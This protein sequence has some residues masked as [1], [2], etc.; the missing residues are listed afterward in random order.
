MSTPVCSHTAPDGHD[1]SGVP[2]QYRH[3]L[4]K[5][6]QCGAHGG[7]GNWKQ[8]AGC[9]GPG[10]GWTSAGAPTRRSEIASRMAATP[11]I[12]AQVSRA[13]T[14]AP[15]MEVLGEF[16]GLIRSSRGTLSESELQEVQEFIEGQD[17][18]L[19]LETLC[20]F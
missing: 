6:R 16:H 18:I 3:W 17:F 7:S 4:P 1:R 15:S 10:G 9:A 2:L 8:S 12:S 5:P 14:V 11:P 19:A 13:H 20:G